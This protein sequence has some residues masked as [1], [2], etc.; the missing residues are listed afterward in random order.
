[1][2]RHER[3]SEHWQT[4]D[5][6][7]IL[8]DWCIR[9]DNAFS[10]LLFAPIFKT[11]HSHF[12][13][14]NWNSVSSIWYLIV[15]LFP[16]TL[17]SC[18][19]SPPSPLKYSSHLFHSLE[20]LKICRSS[21]VP[22]MCSTYSTY[23]FFFFY[24]IYHLFAHLLAYILIPAFWIYCSGKLLQRPTPSNLMLI[25]HLTPLT[26]SLSVSHPSLANS[27]SWIIAVKK[28]F[29]MHT[30]WAL[31]HLSLSAPLKVYLFSLILPCLTEEPGFIHI[32][33]L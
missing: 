3:N 26:A 19:P 30:R 31:Q 25:H 22:L 4:I 18:L 2:Q 11:S 20:A 12:Y 29:S 27:R 28:K 17:L 16:L 14:L 24:T 8:L 21:Q 13:Y 23:I 1:M 10:S 9:R 33:T 7:S 32:H 6:T 15:F 5:I